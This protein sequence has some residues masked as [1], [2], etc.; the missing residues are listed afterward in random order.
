MLFRNRSFLVK[1]IKDS[2]LEMTFPNTPPY[3]LPD[4]N[5]MAKIVTKSVST[6]IAV[7]VGADTVRRVVVYAIS[8]KF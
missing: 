1:P 3:M 7:Y 4:F 2:D 5:H 8:A 6:C